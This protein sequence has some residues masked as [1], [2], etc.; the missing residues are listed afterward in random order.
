MLSKA[1]GLNGAALRSLECGYELPVTSIA[2]GPLLRNAGENMD[3]RRLG[4]R[5]RQLLDRGGQHGS[6]AERAM[7]LFARVTGR[8]QESSIDKQRARTTL[9]RL[10]DSMGKVAW[11]EFEDVAA[12][13]GPHL[14]KAFA[15][16]YV[17]STQRC[18]EQVQASLQDGGQTE[19]DNGLRWSRTRSKA[20]V[21]GKSAS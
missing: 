6:K 9:E 15:R 16:Y 4:Q 8:T 13:Y 18:L 14:T 10:L 11:D 20:S 17:R 1:S 12:D 21:R 5:A 7:L 19:P 2:G 3:R